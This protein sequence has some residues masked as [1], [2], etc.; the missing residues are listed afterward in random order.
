[1]GVYAVVDDGTVT[2][3]VV[4]DDTDHADEMGWV[5]VDDL[6][7]WPAIGWTF[8]GEIWTA[9]SD[10]NPPPPLT[11]QVDR[12][13]LGTVLEQVEAATTVAQLRQS[14]TSLVQQ[15]LGGAP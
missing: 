2:N 5:D 13:A 8:D 6:D 15:L 4:C 1:M 14:M 10:E 11:V 7:Q 12:D 3:I 9:P